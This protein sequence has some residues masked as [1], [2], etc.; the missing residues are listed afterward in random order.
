MNN[1]PQGLGEITSEWLGQAMDVQIDA[2]EVTQIAAGEGFMGQ[3]FR[4]ALVSSDLDCPPSVIV[5]LPTADPGG[6]FIGEMMR[7]W[8]REH[9]FYRD[10]A[11]HMA[12]RVPQ[13]LVNIADPPC[14]VLEDLSP[15]VQG[16]HV[17]G[18]TLDEAR[19][20]IDVLARHH[21]A[22]FEHPLLASL[23]WMPGLDD[24]AILTLGPTFEIGWPIFL[25]RF[26]DELPAR[27]LR[28]CEQ[29]VS[30]IPDWIVGHYDEPITIT[31][32]DFRL[33]NMFFHEDGTVAV[34][35]WQLCMRAPGQADLV[36]F[37]ANNLTID[38]RRAHEDDLIERYV[39]GLHANGVPEHA[40]TIDSVRRGYI[41]GLLFYAVSF[42]A[43][44]LTIDPANERGTALF[45]AL[46]RRTFAAVDDLSS[47]AV[48]GLAG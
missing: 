48:M 46:V 30:G 13:V 27:C 40:V 33:D 44:L 16:D 22:W 26:G 32:G 23:T 24:P 15:A 3:L 4:V 38:M 7:V 39:A 43:S 1:T 17:A 5:K 6:H 25:S 42:G 28:W 34:I 41:E 19:R 29:F 45:D 9:C 11:P 10:V 12:I 36:Y 47:G 35:D 8:E 37:C 20:A 14:L 21:A 31:H 2:I 18:A